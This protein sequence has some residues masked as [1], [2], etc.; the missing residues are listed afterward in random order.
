MN[1]FLSNGRWFVS[2]DYSLQVWDEYVAVNSWSGY[3]RLNDVLSYHINITGI[4][5]TKSFGCKPK[6]WSA[7][8]RY[9]G[10]KYHVPTTHSSCKSINDAIYQA[11]RFLTQEIFENACKWFLSRRQI[12]CVVKDD[13]TP[14]LTSFGWPKW[15]ESKGVNRTVVRHY[16]YGTYHT[17]YNRD[18]VVRFSTYKV[19][20]S[21][22]AGGF[23]TVEFNHWLF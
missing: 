4:Y 7:E 18:N 1:N 9:N 19:Y 12:H 15:L 8:L 10:M 11:D 6:R 3:R 22:Y 20:S 23:K 5:K 16:P 17:A 13:L 14:H 21:G 2:R